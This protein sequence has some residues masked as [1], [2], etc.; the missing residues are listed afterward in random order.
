MIR[1]LRALGFFFVFSSFT[2]LAQVGSGELRGKLTDSETKEPLPFVNIVIQAGERQIGGTSD[3]DG[4]YT[5]KP[6]PPGRYD[7]MVSYVGY[8]SQRITDVI[9]RNEKITFLN[10][11]LDPGIR[12]EEFEVIEYSVPLI[13]R[14]GGASGGTVTRE[15]I[16]QLPA[17]SA[18]GI[19]ATVAGVQTNADGVSI[20]GAREENTFYYI[21]GIK[22][23]GS[24]N[25]PQ[26]GIEEVQVMTG[27]IPASYGDVT[28]GV[29]AI[30]TRGAT[31]QYFGG[32]DILTSGFANEDGTGVGLDRYSQTQVEGVFSG[33]LL[34]QKNA[35]G[36]KERALLG[37]FMSGNYR[38]FMD[39][40]P[41]AIGNFK[42][43]DDVLGT[44]RQQPLSFI[45]SGF[46]NAPT[47]DV[48]IDNNGQVQNASTVSPNI[49]GNSNFLFLREDDWEEVPARQNSMFE[50]Y[51][52]TTKIDIATSPKVD[53][54]VGGTFDYT[55]RSNYSYA[56]SLMN[57][58]NNGQVIDWTTRGFVRF[59][60]RLSNQDE[61]GD[62]LIKNAFYSLMLDYTNRSFRS[63]DPRH[64]DN[65]FNYGHVGRFEE[66]ITNNYS[67]NADTIIPGFYHSGFRVL[68][69][70]FT[71]SNTNPDF[72][73]YTS[74]LYDEYARLGFRVRTLDDVDAAGGLRNGRAPA[75]VYDLYNAPGT[76]FNTFQRFNEEQR[77]LTGSLSA[78]VKGH[79]IRLGFEY[80]ELIQRSFSVN[81]LGLW[82][83]ARQL[84]NNHID[85]LDVNNVI[86]T[87]FINGQFFYTFDRL[88]DLGSQSTFDRNL[89]SALG[90][91]PNGNDYIQVDALSPEQLDINFFSA[92][93]L[94][95]QG[96]SYVGYYGYD[97]RGNRQR[98]NSGIDD[99]FTER[100]ENGNF[101]R[102]R[103][104]FAPIYMSGYIMDK[105]A[106]D[107]I[108]FNVGLRV[109]RF[110]ANQPVLKDQFVIGDALNV[111][112][113]RN[114]ESRFPFFDHPGNVRDNWVVYVDD[115][116]NPN[117][118]NG[119]RDGNTWYNAQ[120]VEI[121][122]PRVLRGASGIAPLLRDP[123]QINENLTSDAFEQ[124]TP[125]W[126]F[127][128]RIAFSFPISD[129]A[130]FFAHYDI[131]TQRPVGQNVLNPVDYLFIQQVGNRAIANPN[132]RPTRTVDYEL[133]FQQV[134][135]RTSS[136]KISAFY[137]ETRD[138][139]QARRL[140]EAFPST[141]TSFDNFDFGTI[142]GFSLVYDLRRTG[143]IQL[144]ANY[145]LQFA[146][147]T[148]S[149]AGS[150]INLVN[151]GEP[152]LRVIFPT[153]RDQRHL[154][155]TTFDY[156]FGTGK[157]YNGPI[158]NGKQILARTG[159]NFISTL[160]SG[161]PYSQQR[162]PLGNA[163]INTSGSPQLE[164]TVNGSRLPWQFR[165]DLQIDRSFD[166][167]FGKNKEKPKPAMLNVYLLVN[168]LFN[169]VN[170]INV[171]RFTGNPDD[172]G[173][174]NAPQFQPA[175]RGQLD[176]E[177][178][179]QMYGLKVNSPFNYG[180]ARVVQ[181][182]VRF[183]F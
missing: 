97:A 75:A 151:S 182:G 166:L 112:D 10:I 56:G 121:P 86:D 69:T 85:E 132:L 68:E 55:T 1:C 150:A 14:D 163:F 117:N 64:Q 154:F 74:A 169:T 73:A 40:R 122:D 145:T 82:N 94:L 125:Q 158:V 30:T 38:R 35:Q 22:V 47:G 105:F 51:S 131:L 13:D 23:R 115:L 126:N 49:Q 119:Y 95:N 46:N 101:T 146:S 161:S 162:L 100:D 92:D 128:P 96:A 172:D 180:V 103:A 58:E 135:S 52:V 65:L 33:P 155:I 138:E 159:L 114:P 142:K 8:N 16:A 152:N 130:V 39:S 32:I 141:Y 15:E 28:G 17:R 29:I 139:I 50:G 171:Y 41:S 106:F 167:L 45:Q 88:V 63:W 44:L 90:F 12:L 134:L 127:M 24:T 18:T 36:E 164:G 26:A 5:L 4:N 111:A 54:A 107:D 177:S 133:G 165:T 147:A 173:Y 140:L 9:I 179:R 7:V 136:L 174:L 113:T 19:A 59:T 110:D 81:P 57:Y 66:I 80:E 60:H 6:I 76:P 116:V 160:G 168:N 93:E 157:N 156:R 67:F 118:I 153:D 124:Y 137:R 104:A 91:D 129:E 149:N 99:F 53:L 62:K 21:D 108:V 79:A 31:S 25:L 109:D 148:G 27:G 102:P 143:N 48:F 77:R 61:Q 34:R 120:G 78:D 72:A 20:R 175:I 83:A 170:I 176:E 11:P 89:R 71:P 123:T 70:T 183:D 43:R 3:F 87:Q 84:T 37:F 98:G 2:A 178:F 181:L 42:L 144:R